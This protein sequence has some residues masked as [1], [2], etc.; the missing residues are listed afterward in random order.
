MTLR[1]G[2]IGLGNMGK[3]LASHLVPAGFDTTVYDIDEASVRELVE[4][5]AKLAFGTDAAIFPHG[6]NAKQ[7]AVMV[8]FG[9]TPMQAIQ[10]ATSVNAEL[11]G[12]EADVGAV[13][14]GRY[15]DLV[16]VRG[17]PLDD[18]SVLEQISFVMK[19][20]EVVRSP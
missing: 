8:R 11:F 20:G 1:A 7:F 5:G 12:W 19:G 10:A 4:A 18:V 3:P 15:A 2:F 16:A 14:T 9:M 6:D 13:E 17:N